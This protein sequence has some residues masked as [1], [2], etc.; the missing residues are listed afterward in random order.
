MCAYLKIWTELK[1]H[2][3]QYADILEDVYAAVRGV[4]GPA[5]RVLLHHPH[6]HLL[7]LHG[8]PELWIRIRSDQSIFLDPDQNPI[9]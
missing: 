4:R 8:N 1:P 3:V 9:F 7:P 6:A 2:A 5:R